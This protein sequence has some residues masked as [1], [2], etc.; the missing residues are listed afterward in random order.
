L[1]ITDLPAGWA[2]DNS[3]SSDNTDDPPCLKRVQAV[4][5]TPHEAHAD[6][7]KGADFPVLAQTIGRYDSANVAVDKFQQASALLTGCGDISFDSDGTHITGTIAEMSFPTFGDHSRAWR[8]ELT[9]QGVNV[10]VDTVLIQKGAEMELIALLD[11]DPST[12]DLA[13]FCRT[14]VGKLS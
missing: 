10:G 5:T 1:T 9:A 7:V 6:F 2:V 4:A 12:N 14:A 13:A 11:L 3:P 8:M